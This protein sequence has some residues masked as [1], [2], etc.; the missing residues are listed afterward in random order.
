[1]NNS[2]PNE[3]EIMIPVIGEHEETRVMAECSPEW[4]NKVWLSRAWKDRPETILQLAEGWLNQVR[5]AG[6]WEADLMVLEPR[7]GKNDPTMLCTFELQSF[8]AGRAA[9]KGLLDYAPFL[10]MNRIAVD[11]S[12]CRGERVPHLL[13]KQV[14]EETFHKPPFLDAVALLSLVCQDLAA[15]EGHAWDRRSLARF[16]LNV[17][18]VQVLTQH[19][20]VAH[21]EALHR[22]MKTLDEQPEQSWIAARCRAARTVL[23]Q[24]RDDVDYAL[25]LGLALLGGGGFHQALN[26]LNEQL[27]AA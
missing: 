17:A 4:W 26:Q 6:S 1:M 8:V 19:A 5:D 21:K 9:S 22:W 16:A 18:Q 23:G 24:R 12:M 25:A 27:R 14:V 13:F 10:G 20:T 11:R 3:W 2:N 7:L 15:H